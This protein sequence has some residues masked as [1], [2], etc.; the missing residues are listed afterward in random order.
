MFSLKELLTPLSEDQACGLDL[1]YDAAF[2]ALETAALGTPERQSGETVVAAEPPN[3]PEV[4]E[5]M[6]ALTKAELLP[7]ET[8]PT[9]VSI[10]KGLQDA[11]GADAGT[12]ERDANSVA[13]GA[14]SLAAQDNTVSISVVGAERK[15][16]NVAAGID[17]TDAVN[18]GQLQGQAAQT[19]ASA[20]AFTTANS[21]ATLANANRFKTANS[22]AALT[23]PNASRDIRI[24]A[25]NTALGGRIDRLDR[26]FNQVGEMS[27]AF[28]IMAG[29]IAASGPNRIVAAFGWTAT[30]W[31]SRSAMGARSAAAPRSTSASP[32]AARERWAATA[33]ASSGNDP[34]S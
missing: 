20:N 15:M 31:R 25:L 19:L 10:G 30:R 32:V 3:W 7:G 14:G 29:N 18:V 12:P 4:Y 9:P 8:R 13:L 34:P 6:L 1:A 2:M 27:A 26:G 23:S 33:S 22:A 28:S 21:A 11:A 5:A 24:G 17:V 16:V